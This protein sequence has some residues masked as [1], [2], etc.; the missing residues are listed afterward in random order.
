MPLIDVHKFVDSHIREIKYF[1][2]GLG[3]AGII[4]IIRDLHLV[5]T[6]RQVS[7]IPSKFVTSHITLQGQVKQINHKGLLLINH[8]PAFVI[9]FSS[10][11]RKYRKKSN[12]DMLPVQLA[13]VQMT[14]PG[15]EWLEGNVLHK[16]IWFQLLFKTEENVMCSVSIRKNAL[17]KTNINESL[18]RQGLC[19]VLLEDVTNPEDKVVQSFVA[20]LIAA[21]DKAQTKK[22]W[23]VAGHSKSVGKEIISLVINHKSHQR[24]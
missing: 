20:R 7:D 6:F 16:H 10:W 15:R 23:N 24:D 4:L 5:Q 11:L 14:E 17:F 8:E 9:P 13:N 19:K 3:A 21:E 12:P 18:V 2:F 1:V 22:T